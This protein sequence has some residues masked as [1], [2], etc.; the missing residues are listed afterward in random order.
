MQYILGMCTLLYLVPTD[1]AAT[2]QAGALTLLTTVLLVVNNL[3]KPSR[4][5]MLILKKSLEETAKKSGGK[6]N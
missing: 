2:H 4:A 1:L 3:K 5:N 6:L